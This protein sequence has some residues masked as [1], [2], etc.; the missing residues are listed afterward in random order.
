MVGHAQVEKTLDGIELDWIEVVHAYVYAMPDGRVFRDCVA[1]G[2]RLIERAIKT[3]N[4]ELLAEANHKM[5]TLYLDPYGARSTQDYEAQMRAWRSRLYDELGT[6]IASIPAEDLAMPE[7]LD[8]LAKAEQY[9][10]E[11]AKGRKGKARG[12]SLKALAQTIQWQGILGKN[13][14][15]RKAEI[16]EVC[17]EALKELTIEESPQEWMAVQATLASQGEA[18]DS[19]TVDKVLAVPWDTH[20]KKLGPL[21][22]A[23]LVLQ[24][25]QLFQKAAPE[26]GLTLLLETR[27]IFDAW[28]NEASFESRWI[29]LTG[30]VMGLSPRDPD[31][32][33]KKSIAEQYG[34]RKERA[35]KENWDAKSLAA[36]LFSLAAVSGHT[37]EEPLG[38]QLLDEAVAV[39]PVFTAP[40][41]DLFDYHRALLWT[42]VGVNGVDSKNWGEGIRGYVESM[43]TCLRLK[44]PDRTMN[45]LRRIDDLA[46]RESKDVAVQVA[47]GL[48]PVALKLEGTLGEPAARILRQIVKRAIAG[49]V[50]E[51]NIEVLSALYQI[52]KGMQFAAALSSGASFEWRP[53][54]ESEQLLHRVSAAER[55]LGQSGD[56]EDDADDLV[57]D[58]EAM[59]SS[60]LATGEAKQGDSSAERFYNLQ[61]AF[62]S[63]VNA[64]L[65]NR[66]KESD[67]WWLPLDDIQA[68]LDP[69][70]VLV[71]LYLGAAQGLLAVHSVVI[72][73]DAVKVGAVQHP[74][75]D[76]T[77]VMS[78][79]KH[80]L[81]STPFALTVAD[82]RRDVMASPGPG[83]NVSPEG[84]DSLAEYVGGLFG[85]MIEY[86]ENLRAQGKD[87]L[88]IVPHGPLTSILAICCGRRERPWPTIGS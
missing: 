58:D 6:E 9:L 36:A 5:G 79:G 14:K 49:S 57:L 46:A 87:H 28:G 40:L 17:R 85:Y 51:I 47:V 54:E 82:A 86:L 45:L 32:L 63:H 60:Y 8:A 43:G 15:K 23:N 44:L 65:L 76:S 61:R 39:A 29:Y 50:G 3:K 83:R 21:T 4:D 72:T 77:I 27:P 37:N 52:G 67:R 11:A 25:A 69:R 71:N 1:T 7:P 78:K 81:I 26:R 20:V 33:D 66:A 34:K 19:A 70:T 16:F 18:V 75:P 55:Q 74:F 48:L 59:L 38:L 80:Q 30:A 22:T 41:Q 68:S 53:D 13:P 24:A 10:R 12:L 42:G 88:C 73:R 56:A 64:V 62:D 31:K 2:E 84:E 35:G